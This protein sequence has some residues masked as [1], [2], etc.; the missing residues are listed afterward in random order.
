M[1]SIKVIISTF[2]P[3]HRRV[4]RLTLLSDG[5]LAVS[6]VVDFLLCRLSSVTDA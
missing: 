4:D 6:E 3:Y 1:G 2:V 5:E